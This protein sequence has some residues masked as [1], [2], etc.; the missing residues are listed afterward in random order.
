MLNTKK[1]LAKLLPTVGG[2]YIKFCGVGV[3]W[4][5]FSSSGEWAHSASYGITYT[6]APIVVVSKAEN[7]A[8][9]CNITAVGRTTTQLS[10]NFS[11]TANTK[12]IDWI[13]IGKVS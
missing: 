4:G 11:V 1:L 2:N 3:A 9:P 12:N 7:V 6:A 5:S 10:V 8:S 13:S